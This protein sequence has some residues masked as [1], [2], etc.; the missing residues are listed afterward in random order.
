LAENQ[1]HIPLIRKQSE[2]FLLLAFLLLAEKMSRLNDQ[3]IEDAHKIIDAVFLNSPQYVCEPLGDALGCRVVL[4]VETNNPIRCFKGRGADLLCAEKDE[5]ELVC[6]SA[7]NFG[8]AVAYACRKRNIRLTIFAAVNA[9]QLKIE[10][11]RA[12][13]ANVVLE[14]EDFDAAKV[15]AR[16]FGEEKRIRFVEDGLAV[17]TLIGAGTIGLE[18]VKFSEPIDFLLVPLGNGALFNGVATYFKAKSPATKLIAIQAKGAPAMIESWREKRLIEHEK[19]NT[20]ADGIGVR[21]P[22][23]QSL[24][25]M[26]SLIDDGIL[27]EE[28]SILRAMK[29]LHENAGLVVEPAGAVGVSAILENPAMFA[30][31]TVATIICGSNLTAEQISQWL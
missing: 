2:R 17:E 14:G 30:G 29:L 4:K 26:E 11:M 21:L 5:N 18:L 9:N 10:R 23:A 1:R 15:A 6:A 28:D 12:L 22:V 16:K 27:V 24:E 19:I 7:G 25:D 31:K 8:Q 13:G 3:N 20:I